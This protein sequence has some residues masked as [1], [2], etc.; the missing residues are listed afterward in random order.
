[1]QNGDK[2]IFPSNPKGLKINPS[3]FT[4]QPNPIKTS[5]VEKMPLLPLDGNFIF[6]KTPWLSW[7]ELLFGFQRGYV[8]EKG[9]SHFACNTLTTASSEKAYE[10]ASLEPHELYL[11]S[12]LLQSLTSKNPQ[13]EKEIYK[14]WIYLLLSYFLENKNSLSNPLEVTEELYA[15]FD[16]PGEISPIVR[17]MPIPDGVEGSEERLYE[18]WRLAILEYK[19]LFS[20][21]R[22]CIPPTTT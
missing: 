18:N 6:S 20:C 10:L 22:D 5:K 12:D 19:A 11:T 16:Y 2:S 8:D 9:I 15:D 13:T 3:P 17:Y 7:D 4:C 14:P 1:M 21:E